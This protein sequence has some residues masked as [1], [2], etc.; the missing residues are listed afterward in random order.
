MR[1]WVREHRQDPKVRAWL[2]AN[3]PPA[4]WD[5]SALEWAY[6]ER[7]DVSAGSIVG[8]LVGGAALLGLG[9]LALDWLAPQ[10]PPRVPPAMRPP[11]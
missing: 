7:P 9:K 4:D 5:G 3:P 2:K 10:P 11:L 8:V 1:T 6:T